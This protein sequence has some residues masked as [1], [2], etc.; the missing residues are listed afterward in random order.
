MPGHTWFRLS[1]LS[2]QLHCAEDVNNG[3]KSG[4][5]LIAV[6]AKGCDKQTQKC[7]YGRT[8][9]LTTLPS[10]HQGVEIRS[11]LLKTQLAHNTIVSSPPFLILTSISKFSQLVRIIAAVLTGQFTNPP[12]VA[13]TLIISIKLSFVKSACK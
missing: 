9:G 10:H 7:S 5:I 11:P 2:E 12:A 3:L 6:F 1:R 8:T 13:V 4:Y